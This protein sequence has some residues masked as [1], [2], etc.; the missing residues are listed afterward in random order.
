MTRELEPRCAAKEDR[1]GKRHGAAWVEFIAKRDKAQKKSAGFAGEAAAA[2]A[3]S[4]HEAEPRFRRID[5]LG[6]LGG[7]IAQIERAAG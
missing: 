6:M 7:P 2:E 3:Q 1:Q 5:H 4:R